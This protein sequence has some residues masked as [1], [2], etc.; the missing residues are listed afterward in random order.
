MKKYISA[1]LIVLFC[2]S[3]VGCNSNV[4][5]V[6]PT[7][8]N[9]TT[10]ATAPTATTETTK[11][12]QSSKTTEIQADTGISGKD[13]LCKR[14]SSLQDYKNEFIKY[15]SFED[16]KQSV[17]YTGEYDK[18][19]RENTSLMLQDKCFMVME[20]PNMSLLGITYYFNGMY[21]SFLYKNSDAEHLMGY[22][23][24]RKTIEYDKVNLQNDYDVAFTTDDGCPVY[25]TKLNSYYYQWYDEEFD[26][27]FFVM[28][29]LIKSD[30][31]AKEII[32]NLKIKKIM[33]D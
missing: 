12:I 13:Y 23:T 3:V 28:S 6:T 9:V 1:L 25:R 4:E 20:Y 21:V 29:E 15:K 33:I 7:T 32:D 10:T 8:T 30:S 5:V 27:S 24:S 18:Y 31:E 16:I 22:D 2:L 11:T 14:F 26:C 19:A 17:G